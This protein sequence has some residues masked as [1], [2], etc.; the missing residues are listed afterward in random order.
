MGKGA[1]K[2]EGRGGCGLLEVGASHGQ[3]QVFVV[4]ASGNG[5]QCIDSRRVNTGTQSPVS[6]AVS[7]CE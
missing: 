3:L 6:N 2:G 7:S 5:K 1:G 4:Q